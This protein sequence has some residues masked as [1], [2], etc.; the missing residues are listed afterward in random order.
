MSTKCF[1]GPTNKFLV[2]TPIGD[3]ELECCPKGIHSLCLVEG[4]NDTNF[5]PKPGKSVGLLSQ[6]Y[7]D[8]GYTYK[9]AVDCVSWLEA[10]FSHPEKR[11]VATPSICQ[12]IGREGSFTYKVWFTLLKEV[13]IGQTISYGGLARLCG[14]V[15]ACRAVGQAM[16]NNPVGLIIP[17]HRVI[18]ENGQLGNYSHGTRNK[19]KQWLLEHEGS[20]K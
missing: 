8:N 18:Q 2:S 3:V 12:H 7:K 19:V 15:K 4:V 11:L 16:R 5:N 6:T 10:Y 1:Y 20:C 14:N 9:P 13:Q 17:C